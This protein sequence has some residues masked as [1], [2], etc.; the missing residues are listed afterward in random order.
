MQIDKH[1]FE[2]ELELVRVVPGRIY[3]EERR[4]WIVPQ[5]ADL[6]GLK[7][8]VE[9][10]KRQLSFLPKDPTMVFQGDD[11]SIRYSLLG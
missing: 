1:K 8:A 6:P 5:T 4:L 9:D 2:Q 3:D 11:W 10:S 7:V